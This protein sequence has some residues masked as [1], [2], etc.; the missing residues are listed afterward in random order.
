MRSVENEENVESGKRG[1][2]KIRSL[3]NVSLRYRTF[4]FQAKKNV[5]KKV[6]K[7]IKRVKHYCQ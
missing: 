7:R 6:N 1:V 5:S 3:E 4:F 2:W